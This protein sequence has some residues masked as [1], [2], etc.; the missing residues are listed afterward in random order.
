MRSTA[1]QGQRLPI[2]ADRHA[3]P[4]ADSLAA[5]VEGNRFTRPV[6]LKRDTADA[7]AHDPALINIFF[8]GGPSPLGDTGDIRPVVIG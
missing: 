2:R 4:I 3:I 8:G 5:W 7:V 1:C 6:F